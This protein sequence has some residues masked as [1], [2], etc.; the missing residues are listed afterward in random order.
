MEEIVEK[1]PEKTEVN[2]RKFIVGDR[3]YHSVRDP[4]TGYDHAMKPFLF[5]RD[6]ELLGGLEGLFKKYEI[7]I[8]PEAQI[9][10]EERRIK[11]LGEP[12]DTAVYLQ[13]PSNEFGVAVG[14]LGSYGVS[15]DVIRGENPAVYRTSGLL[16][17]HIELNP[18]RVS[19]EVAERVATIASHFPGANV[20][21]YVDDK[22][23]H[24]V[25]AHDVNRLSSLSSLSGMGITFQA[26]AATSHGAEALMCMHYL[27]RGNF[28]L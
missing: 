23:M 24:A 27:A 13:Q 6:L 20:H 10:H 16:R 7:D 26:D 2:K 4:V 11:A 18:G 12:L 5:A 1:M 21:A 3:P 8:S 19:A 25:P 9:K 22:F 17:T 14:T 15:P 28:G